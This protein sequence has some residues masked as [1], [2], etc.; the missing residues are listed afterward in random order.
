MRLVIEPQGVSAAR[1]P[2]RSL[3]VNC[4]FRW[5]HAVPASLVGLDGRVDF[6]NH[7]LCETLYLDEW[8][9]APESP[10][11]M[12][13][14]DRPFGGTM[15]APVSREAI[16]FV[17]ERRHA[18]YRGDVPLTLQVRFRWHEALTHLPLSP[19]DEKSGRT[20]TYVGGAVVWDRCE[21]SVTVPQSEWLKRLAEMEWG[22]TEVF[23]IP[24]LP[25]LE[26]PNL[27]ESFRLIR[28][29]EVALRT[30]DYKGVLVRC[31]EALESAAKYEVQSAH[32]GNLK[33]GY[34]QLLGRA[35]PEH[36]AK[37]AELNDVML[38]L[39]DFFHLGRHANYPA[40][41]VSREEAEF[42][43]AST[44]GLFSMIS[45]RLANKAAL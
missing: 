42:A 37:P 13:Y 26:D 40:L 3:R 12:H 39:N 28:E 45:R 25:M 32:Q 20:V 11:V 18:Q 9:W 14:Q 10:A 4:R 1:G 35:F 30:G 6:G 44:A 24:A 41:H 19:R 22:Q 5:D 43:Y 34:G 7:V 15:V 23:E 38:K 31:R 16:A 36:E 8:Q 27:A 33:N 17:E 29:A 21:C 2:Q